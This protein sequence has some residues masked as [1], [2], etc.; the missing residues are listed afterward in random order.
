[1]KLLFVVLAK[2]RERHLGPGRLA[3]KLI[4]QGVGIIDSFPVRRSDNIARM[5]SRL[6]GWARRPPPN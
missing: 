4:S 1:M 6:V 5:N 2:D 3:R